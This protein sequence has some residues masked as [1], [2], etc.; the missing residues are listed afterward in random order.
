MNLTKKLSETINTNN[1]IF[2]L[3]LI[4]LL[5]MICQSLCFHWWNRGF[6]IWVDQIYS[7]LLFRRYSRN[8]FAIWVSTCGGGFHPPSAK[9]PNRSIMNGGNPMSETINVRGPEYFREQAEREYLRQ[10]VRLVEKKLEEQM[11]QSVPEAI[12]KMLSGMFGNK[13]IDIKMKL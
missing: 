10:S 6:L 11:E 3:V 1:I 5:K 2:I 8:N 7:V 12:D 9:K 4:V 13:K